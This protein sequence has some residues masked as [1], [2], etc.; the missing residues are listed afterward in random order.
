M[1]LLTFLVHITSLV[2]NNLTASQ[3]T[4]KNVSA[5][6]IFYQNLNICFCSGM[7]FSLW[8]CQFEGL[9]RNL[10][11]NHDVRNAVSGS[12]PLLISLENTSS[13]AIYE[14]YLIKITYLS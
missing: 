7:A 5:I 1:T 12:K 10:L 4:E 13:T 6:V 2:V 3:Y 14:H 9:G 11:L 8:W